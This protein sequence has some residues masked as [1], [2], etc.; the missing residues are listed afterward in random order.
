MFFVLVRERVFV[1]INPFFFFMLVSVNVCV[2]VSR[3]CFV[4]QS[5]LCH[6]NGV[7]QHIPWRMLYKYNNWM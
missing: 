6:L 1:F 3:V 2:L 5:V 7:K 4:C